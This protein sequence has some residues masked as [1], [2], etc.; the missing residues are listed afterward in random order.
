MLCLIFISPGQ[1]C[2]S[3]Q[4]KLSLGDIGLRTASAGKKSKK[5]YLKHRGFHIADSLG[6]RHKGVEP[7]RPMLVKIFA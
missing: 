4:K 2:I 6:G 3:C 5:A 1:S 7:V